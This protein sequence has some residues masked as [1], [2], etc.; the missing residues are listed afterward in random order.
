MSSVLYLGKMLMNR[1]NFSSKFLFISMLFFFPLLLTNYYLIASFNEGLQQT[2]LEMQGLKIL[3]S[4]LKARRLLEDASE[5][6]NISAAIDDSK[7]EMSARIKEDLLG[8]RESLKQLS[9]LVDKDDSLSIRRDSLL[10]RVEE[11]EAQDSPP[12]KAGLARQVFNEFLIFNRLVLNSASLDEDPNREVRQMLS[13]LTETTPIVSE[14]LSRSRVIGSIAFGQ[15]FLDSATVSSL[16]YLQGDL[17]KQ[18]A[19]YGDFLNEILVAA[20]PE[21]KQLAR[22]SHHSLQAAGRILEERIMLAD[23]L[24]ASWHEF[25][26]EFGSQFQSIQGL[27]DYLL[28]DISFS[29]ERR[30]GEL[31][32]QILWLIILLFLLFLVIGYLY[33]SFYSSIRG[34]LNILGGVMER[35][36][37]GDMTVSCSLESRDELGQLGALVNTTV[38]RMHQLI[39]RVSLTSC[40]VAQHSERVRAIFIDC[41]GAVKSQRLQI[42]QVVTAMNEMAATSQEVAN[43][44]SVSVDLAA[45]VNTVTK[46]GLEQANTQ[47]NGI[48]RLADEVDSSAGVIGQLATHSNSISRV[49]DVIKGVAQQT[50]LLALNAAIEA[51]R[52]GDQGRGFAVVADEVRNLAR[53]TQEL[54]GEIEGMIARLQDGV[55]AVVLAMRTSLRSAGDTVNQSAEVQQALAS[56]MLAVETIVDQSHQIAA[57]AEEQTAVVHDIEQ[58]MMGISQSSESTAL[59]A[60]AAVDACNQLSSQMT[61]LQYLMGTFHLK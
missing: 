54:A 3:S 61:N 43:N 47:A 20:D 38:E 48:R 21:L 55:A 57:A 5:L 39:E 26:G 1:L 7:F 45:R 56:I 15:G 27:E 28:E 32:R 18:H 44:A 23:N 53:R 40:A 2:Q 8:F 37:E 6:I 22:D 51:A 42:E 46:N 11:L 50:N 13:L 14:L 33:Y 25:Y 10:A 58:N 19:E 35:L 31:S 30:Y 17:E 34:S 36:A 29:L 60:E 9:L 12:D 59:G 16:E 49:L 4:L 41:S 24:N 52:A